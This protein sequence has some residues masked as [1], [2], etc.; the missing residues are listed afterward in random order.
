VFVCLR[1]ACLC[2][3]TLK[4]PLG[5][6]STL[7]DLMSLWMIT[8]VCACKYSTALPMSMHI[9]TASCSLKGS[10]FSWSIP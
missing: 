5:A 10:R 8:G 9:C 4:A 6:T 1:C 7:C 2:V 3:L